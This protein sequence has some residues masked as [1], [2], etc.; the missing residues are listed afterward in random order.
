MKYLLTTMNMVKK[1]REF[2]EKYFKSMTGETV[3]KDRAISSK[4][5]HVEH[6]K[7]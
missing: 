6:T 1:L 3:L 5:V 2:Y 4:R 7:S